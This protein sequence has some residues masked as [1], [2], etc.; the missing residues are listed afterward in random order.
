M[1]F[2][3]DEDQ[4]DA[5]AALARRHGSDVTCSH[6]AGLDGRVDDV[7][8]LHAGREGRALV[9]KN[10]SDFVRFTREFERDG[11]PHAG[12]LFLPPSLPNEDFGGIARAI[13]AYDRDHPEGMLPYTWDWLR[14][15]RD[16]AS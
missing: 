13:V 15:V 11:L 9:T 2:Y 4:S 1:R 16:D 14:R 10:Y 12:V 3:L 6:E 5:A 8:L 7:Q